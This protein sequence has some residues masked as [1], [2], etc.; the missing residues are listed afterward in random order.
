LEQDRPIESLNVQAA[1]LAHKGQSFAGQ[2]IAWV[3]LDSPAE[4]A[5]R[6]LLF[7]SI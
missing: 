1:A 6:A 5:Q 3:E 4:Q 7:A 2:G